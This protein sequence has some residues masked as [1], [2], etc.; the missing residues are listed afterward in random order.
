MIDPHVQSL[1]D[2]FGVPIVPKHRYPAIGETR[3]VAAIRKVIERGGMDD[4]RVVMRTLTGTAG[5]ASSMTLPNGW[6]SGTF[7]LWLNCRPSRM[8]YAASFLCDPHWP[9]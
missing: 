2:E 4:A 5:I 8:I 6:K 3:A 1:C 7:A 9:A